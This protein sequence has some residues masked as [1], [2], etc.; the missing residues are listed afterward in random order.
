[1][2][3]AGH[4]QPRAVNVQELVELFF[5]PERLPALRNSRPE[6]PEVVQRYPGP[7]NAMGYRG[8]E[9]DDRGDFNIAYLGCSWVEGL[10]ISRE[11]LFSDRVSAMLSQATGASVRSWNLGLSGSSIDYVGR[12][13]P[14]TVNVLRPDCVVI[15]LTTLERRD[16]FTADGRR[17]NLLR[18]LANSELVEANR[19]LVP[20]RDRP[21][22]DAFAA[23][24]NRYSNVAHLLRTFGLWRAFLE[25][26]DTPFVFTHIDRPQLSRSIDE[27]VRLGAL[28]S[29]S[30]LGH[31]FEKIDRAAPDNPHP[32]PDS[33]ERFARAITQWITDRDLVGQARSSSIRRSPRR[34]GAP[35]TGSPS[36]RVRRA[37]RY[38]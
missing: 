13:L 38:V 3:L 35:R 12:L 18:Y 8:D 5:P 20:A 36:S 9:F 32:G 22:I 1:M 2:S 31:P 7:R 34:Q 19:L 21:S 23:L 37:L 25:A 15:V 29:E 33:H 28:P 11:R 16:Y 6:R 27:L 17:L 10:G 14:G 24:S 26:S 4:G 30:Y